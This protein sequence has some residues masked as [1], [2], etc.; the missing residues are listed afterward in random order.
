MKKLFT[1][2]FLNTLFFQIFAN[3]P[4]SASILVQ[5]V[6][7]VIID[8][9]SKT[10][11]IGANVLVLNSENSLGSSTDLDGNFKIQEVPVG[12]ISLKITYIGYHDLVLQNLNLT[13]GKE[14]FLNLEMEEKV[15]M[16][17]EVV[18]KA[19]AN[20][21]ESQNKMTTVSTR[22]FT[23]EETQRYAGSRNDVGRM[24]ANFAGVNGTDDARN[25]IIVR[26][27][28]PIG[29]LW[30]LE[31]V[32]I[33]NPNHF[34]AQGTTG[35]PVCMLNNNVLSNSDF[36][37][38]AF[39]AE[40]GNAISGV[41]DLKMRNGNNE[42]FEFLGQVGFNGFELMAEG[43]ISR[44]NGSSFVASYRLSTLEAM[45]AMGFYFGT[46]TGIPKYQDLTFKFNFPKTK[47]GS[48][49]L[50]GI[51]GISEIAML[52]SKRD[53]TKEENRLDY[54]AG[55]GQD[56]KFSADMATVGTT[57]TYFWNKNTFS[58][59]TLSYGYRN[60]RTTIDTISPIDKKTISPFYRN[61]SDESKIFASFVLNKKFNSRNTAKVGVMYSFINNSFVD[62]AYIYSSSRF[63]TMHDFD[64]NFSLLQPY[65]QWQFKI[66]EDWTLNTG[67]HYNYF[68][69]NKTQSIEPRAGVK[70]QLAGNHSLNF[71]YGYHSQ[72]NPFTVYFNQV[73][74]SD[75]LTYI[76]SNENLDM[77]HSQHFVLGYDWNIT[78]NTRVKFETYYQY[79]N[80]VGID[81]ME[82]NSFSIL[83]QGAN[84]GVYT[85]DYLVSTGTGSNYGC[86]FTLE[87]FF[88]KGFYYLLTASVYDSKYKGSD[89]VERNTAFNG[90][91][92][93]NALIGKEFVLGNK[94]KEA[95]KLHIL[96]FDLKMTYSGGQRYTPVDIAKSIANQSKI[97]I[98]NEA[99]TKKFPDYKRVDLKISYKLN[100]KRITQ[101]WGLEI[102]NL[103]DN[104]NPFNQKF[105]KKTGDISYSYQLGRMIIPQYR[106]T[107]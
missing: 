70:W 25:D 21:G 32:D 9:S 7:G 92:I 48:F 34:A 22:G 52:D 68:A 56:L 42:K 104:K 35:G 4:N 105:N 73:I 38:G 84:F 30:R 1:F 20:K 3:N 31:G 75:S 65:I 58:K 79:I 50:F 78:E 28:S 51:G 36:M 76:K 16:G 93:T 26:G 55:E 10:P 74:N 97:L 37:T 13:S 72:T 66:T 44:K 46:G 80:N 23:V 53:T 24:A 89:K 39:P 5:T 100:G 29:L 15:I 94:K 99:F 90:N 61:Y 77:I 107:F 12:R 45:A 95:K 27:N 98:D 102:T 81:K 103:L 59:F 69:F 43:P 54:D 71:A 41:F 47:L 8:K 62:S 19:N 6:R 67:I 83:N 91:Y 85:K 101:E 40:Y 60:N 14:L 33:F 57:N 87:R 2:L 11:L 86:E 18:I 88:D 82:S 64:G 63:F 17:K 106:I 49:T 96:S